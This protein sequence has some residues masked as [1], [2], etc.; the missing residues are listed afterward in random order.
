[1]RLAIDMRLN[2]YRAGGIPHYSSQL[3]AALAQIVAPQDRILRI[4]HRRPPLGN[5]ILGPKIERRRVWTPPHNRWE[6]WSLPIELRGLRADVIHFPDYIPLFRLRTSSVITV[7]DLAFL[8]YPEILD[9]EARAYYG[10]IRRAVDHAHAII[11]VSHSTKR[12]LAELL[13]VDPQRVDVVHEAAAAHFH[14]L[15]TIQPQ[16]MINGERLQA[17]SF[18][19]FVGTVEPRK[20][21][22]TLLRA[23]HSLEDRVFDPAPLLVIAGPR[24]WLDSDIYALVRELKIEERVRFVGGVDDRDLVWLYNAC[25]V[26]LHPE[27]YSG[28]GLPVLE[29]MQCGAPTIVADVS[30]LPE[31]VGDAGV[32]LPPTDIAAWAEAWTRLWHDDAGRDRLRRAGLARAAQFSWT[33]AA[34]QTLAIY[35]RVAT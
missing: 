28:F 25:R 27:L 5:P 16:R 12:D 13:H 35:R 2:S 33:S 30:S 8:R 17:G 21:L 34:Q 7:H 31:V 24:G 26:Y 9:D 3:L 10:Q 19:L 14:P 15:E 32:L 23:L 11:A 4:E 6:Q 18:A 29:A 1:M 20:N 22:Q